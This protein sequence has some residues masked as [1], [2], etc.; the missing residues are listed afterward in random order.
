MYLA[1]FVFAGPSTVFPYF[2][3]RVRGSI[4]PRHALVAIIKGVDQL[5]MFMLASI[6]HKEKTKSCSN[7]GHSQFTVVVVGVG[8]DRS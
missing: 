4:I 2:P 3:S 6:I 7:I 1:V 8:V 5:I